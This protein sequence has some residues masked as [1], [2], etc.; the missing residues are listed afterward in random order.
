MKAKK[1]PEDDELKPEE[2]ETVTG[3]RLTTWTAGAVT[4][5]GYFDDAYKTTSD[6]G[7][8]GCPARGMSK[9]W[10]GTL[11]EHRGAGHRFHAGCFL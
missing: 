6:T 11:E 10:P 9:R 2:P 4:V 8:G 1:A 5:V 7:I 3:A